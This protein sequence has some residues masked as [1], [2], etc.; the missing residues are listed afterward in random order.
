[1]LGFIAMFLAIMLF[2]MLG[3]RSYKAL[4]ALGLFIG[5]VETSLI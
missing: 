1:M 4:F 3:I 5:L 2:S